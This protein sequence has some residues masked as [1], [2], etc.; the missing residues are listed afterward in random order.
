MSE[1]IP[2]NKAIYKNTFAEFRDLDRGEPWVAKYPTREDLIFRDLTDYQK[3]MRV[4]YQHSSE[5]D[6]DLFPALADGEILLLSDD[7]GLIIS[8]SIDLDYL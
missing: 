1:I 6:A 4:L 7:Y 2:D 3:K 8:Q 5:P